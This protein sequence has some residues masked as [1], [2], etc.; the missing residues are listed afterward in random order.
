MKY[1]FVIGYKQCDGCPLARLN[2]AEW[3]CSVD[4]RDASIQ[5]DIDKWIFKGG[6]APKWCP[7]IEDR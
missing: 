7:L 1:K 4:P 5:T 3:Y 2:F 6:C